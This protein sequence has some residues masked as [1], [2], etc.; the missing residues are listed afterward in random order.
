A[1]LKHVDKIVELIAGRGDPK[2]ITREF[3]Q[4]LMEL[5]R[6]GILCQLHKGIEPFIDTSECKVCFE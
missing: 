5:R 2:D 1:I 6:K 4:L 3:N